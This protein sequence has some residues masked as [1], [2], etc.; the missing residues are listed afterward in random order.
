MSQSEDLWEE[1]C[2]FL[3]KDFQ[4][5]VE[6]SK[7]KLN[8]HLKRWSK[9]KTAKHI[10]PDGFDSIKDI[11]ITTYEDY[12]IFRKYGN[13]LEGELEKHPK[14]EGSLWKDHYEKIEKKHKDMVEDW[15]PGEYGGVI[16]TTGTTGDS[17]WVVQSKGF[18]ENLGKSTIQS[19]ILSASEEMG[20][21]SVERGDTILNMGV[22]VPYMMG[23][24]QSYCRKEFK[25][26]PPIEVTDD[27]TKMQDKLYYILKKLQRGQKL[28]VAGAV[29][30]TLYIFAK[31]VTEP[32]ELYHD[33]FESM[34]F[35]INK[36][37]MGI[38]YLK[39]RLGSNKASSAKDI[40][41]TKGLLTAGQSTMLYSDYLK[42]Q[43]GKVPLNIYASTELGTIMMGTPEHRSKLVPNL[44]YGHL[45]FIDKGDELHSIQEVKE[46]NVYKLV[47]TP[48]G[49]PMVR[50]DQKDLLRVAEIRDDGMPIFEFESRE[51]NTLSVSNYFILNQGIAM[52]ILK[53]AGWRRSGNW[54][55]TKKIGKNEKLHFIMEK[56][57]E[58]DKKEAEKKI[59]SALKE[60]TEFF[61]NYIRDFGIVEPSDVIEVEYL[62]KGSFKRY[63]LDKM[64]SDKP[65]GQYKPPRVISPQEKDIVENLRAA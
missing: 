39:E 2:S 42:E 35:G 51:V 34:D 61:E 1:H 33:Y 5:Q 29:A 46:G 20:Q 63:S 53:R 13:K 12:P 55:V 16:K 48:F 54:A 22:S 32:D 60:E 40:L 19:V 56:D 64:T 45:E 30:P 58:Y 37:A 36:I 57:W 17:K 24:T 6:Q 44:Q 21:T 11:P 8:E 27:M 26:F 59:F 18:F 3:Q 14:P 7:K 50:Y 15:I 49:S 9:T 4:D 23:Y 47:G 38:I 31:A 65:L 28:H 52:R 43:F 41:E 62:D 25:L 10:C